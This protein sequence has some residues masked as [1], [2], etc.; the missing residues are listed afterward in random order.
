[1]YIYIYIYKEPPWLERDGQGAAAW[2]DGRRARAA[3]DH[4]V[5]ERRGLPIAIAIL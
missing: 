5:P 2:P 3:Q 1:M 4:P